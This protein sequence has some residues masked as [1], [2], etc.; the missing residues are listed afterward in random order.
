MKRRSIAVAMILTTLALLGAVA[1]AGWFVVR[2][3]PMKLP[4]EAVG[5]TDHTVLLANERSK[6]GR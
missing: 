4:L 3:N 1:L 2:K 6:S 5:I